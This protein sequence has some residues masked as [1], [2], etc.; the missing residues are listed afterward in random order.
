MS[1]NTKYVGAAWLQRH[2]KAKQWLWFVCLWIGGLVTAA[3]LSYPLKW[4]VR[5]L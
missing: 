1:I 3:S 4:L 5:Y 2:P